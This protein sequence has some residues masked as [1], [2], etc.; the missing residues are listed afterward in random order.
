MFR[1]KQINE[2]TAAEIR[3]LLDAKAEAVQT[4]RALIGDDDFNEDTSA[5][6]VGLLE[7]DMERT[8]TILSLM[9]VGADESEGNEE[10]MGRD[11]EKAIDAIS[12]ILKGAFDE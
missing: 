6:V 3:G 2:D 8:A 5:E 4:I 1:K 10:D 7:A 9:G 11:E 12:I